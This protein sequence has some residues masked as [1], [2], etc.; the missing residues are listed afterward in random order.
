MAFEWLRVIP[1]STFF[2]LFLSFA[3]SFATSFSNRVLTNREQLRAWSK[4]IAEWRSDSLKARRTGDKKLMAKVKKQEK[5]IM[6]LQWKMSRQQLKTSV[7]WFIPLMLMW[8]VFLPQIINIYEVVA[9]LPWF[10]EELR[11]SVFLWYLL[12][13]FLVSALFTRLFGLGMGGD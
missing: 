9:Y 5:H 12:S 3:V 4:E 10:G 6:Q 7:L 13:S 11:L 8:Y 1:Y 2:I